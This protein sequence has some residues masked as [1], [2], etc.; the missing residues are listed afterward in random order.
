[1]RFVNAGLRMHVPSIVG[2]QTGTVAGFS[3]IAEDGN[4]LPGSARVQ[5]EVFL[6][7]GKTYDVMVNV[8]AA[9]G[10]ALPVFDRELSLSGNATARDAGMLAYLGINGAGLPAAP[11]FSPG[12]LQLLDSVRGDSVPRIYRV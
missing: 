9:G 7:A 10:S 4:P 5:S 11:A 3:L 12:Y 2:A 1:V 6:A 8:P